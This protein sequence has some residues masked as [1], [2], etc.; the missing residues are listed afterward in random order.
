MKLS[1]FFILEQKK[2]YAAPVQIV[3]WPIL[4]LDLINGLFG[5]PKKSQYK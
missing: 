1:W 5:V 2:K 3:K 4:S